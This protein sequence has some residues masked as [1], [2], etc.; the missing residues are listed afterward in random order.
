[1]VA[2]AVA[3]ATVATVALVAMAAM[4]TEVAV[5]LAMA[6]YD[7]AMLVVKVD[8]SLDL[9]QGYGTWC[10]TPKLWCDVCCKVTR[11]NEYRKTA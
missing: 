8:Y 7:R 2:V 9:S 6:M 11:S 10:N 3:V 1:M 4:G 5:A